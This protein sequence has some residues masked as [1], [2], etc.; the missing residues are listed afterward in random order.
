MNT[1]VLCED[2]VL[3]DDADEKTKMATTEETKEEAEE[4]GETK[5]ENEETEEETEEET[6]KLEIEKEIMEAE[7]AEEAEIDDIFGQSTS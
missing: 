6:K 3:E 5:D 7:R 2:I 1:L 4:E